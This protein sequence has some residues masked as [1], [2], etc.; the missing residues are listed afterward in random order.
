MGKKKS[1]TK[2]TSTLTK[3]NTEP[4]DQVS[5]STYSSDTASVQLD[6]TPP[7][8]FSTGVD[9]PAGFH[10]RVCTLLRNIQTQLGTI[11]SRLSTLER[12]TL[13]EPK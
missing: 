4:A 7:L 1:S 8:A 9:D 12:S 11:E 3:D 13:T 10:D 6:R 2:H 5:I